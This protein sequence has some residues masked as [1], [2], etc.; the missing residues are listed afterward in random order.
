[1]VRADAA[2]QLPDQHR[3]RCARGRAGPDRCRAA[4]PPAGAALDV[5]RREPMLPDDPLWAV[6][7]ITITPH[8]AAQSS[9]Q[10]IAA[11]FIAGLR[12]IERGEAPPQLVDRERGY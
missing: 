1:R 12:C 10:T 4:R 8:I 7:G 2:G 3:A 6:P 5:Q 9:P 11:Q